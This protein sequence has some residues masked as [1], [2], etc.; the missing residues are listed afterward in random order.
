MCLAISKHDNRG[1]SWHHRSKV[2][3]DFSIFTCTFSHKN[4]NH[5][6]HLPL[7]QKLIFVQIST[8]RYTSWNEAQTSHEL[9]Y[10]VV[11]E[12]VI[13]ILWPNTDFFPSRIFENFG[14]RRI[15]A[16]DSHRSM[17]IKIPTHSRQLTG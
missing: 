1:I 8:H 14:Y 3:E 10:P 4:V 7:E 16:D 6:R 15:F 9:R 12:T 2:R 5:E 11:S 17:V 13:I